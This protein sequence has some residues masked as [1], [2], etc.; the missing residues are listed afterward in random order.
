MS[1]YRRPT[2]NFFEEDSQSKKNKKMSK[3][4]EKLIMNTGAE[5]GRMTPGSGN[6]GIKGDV[7]KR[8]KM[9]EAKTT[10]GRQITV[11]M[12]WLQKLETEAW[13]AGKEPV[14]V[15]GF[16]GHKLTN[17]NWGAVP[18]ERLEELFDIER[19]YKEGR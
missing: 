4:Q 3:R 15:F 17:T 1:E 11:K 6:K 10:Q 14:F 8:G 7:W 19:K 13:S 9:Y 2:F 18:L 12:D 5:K 16:E